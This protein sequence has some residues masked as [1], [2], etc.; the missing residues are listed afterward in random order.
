MGSNL[1]N[2]NI[3]CI[4]GLDTARQIA[5]PPEVMAMRLAMVHRLKS[6]KDYADEYQ[7]DLD[8]RTVEFDIGFIPKPLH[9]EMFGFV[10]K[11]AGYFYW[12]ITDH[13]ELKRC[14]YKLWLY[15]DKTP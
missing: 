12:E 15:A 8:K 7:I 10:L 2:T 14:T 9:R 13:P 4:P 3:I 1:G 6:S 11:D 5:E